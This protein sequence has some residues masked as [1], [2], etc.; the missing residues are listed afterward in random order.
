[1]SQNST[2]Q[3]SYRPLLENAL[4][5]LRKTRTK[6]ETIKEAQ[7]EPIAIIGMG[8]R[9]PGGVDTPDKFWSL[10]HNGVDAITDIPPSR[11]DI[12]AY[13]DSDPDA[14]GKMYVKAG[15]FLDDVEQF[16]PLFFGMAPREAISL[17]PQQR[18]L[19]EVCW[20]ALENAGL[21]ADKLKGSKTGVFVGLFW[22]DY[23]ASHLYADDTSQIDGYRMLSNLRSLSAG[24][25]AYILGLHGP[26]MQVDTACS[27]S[28]LATHL[29]CQS[30]RNQ[31]CHLAIAGGTSL[32]LTPQETI[33]LCRIRALAADGRCKTFDA[34]ADGF[35]QGEGCGL[36]VLKRLS[37]AL[38]DGDNIL[39]LIRGSAVNHDGRSNGLTVPNGTAQEALLR[40]ALTNAA[41]E[42]EQIQY[43]EAHGTGTSLGDPIEVLALAKVLGQ[44]R[45]A[46]LAMGT[47]KTNLGHLKS[48]AGVASLMKVVLS[49]QHAEIPPHLHLTEPNPHIPWDELPL[50]VPTEPT[51]WTDETKRAGVSSFGMS[52]TNVHV[53]VEEAPKN[54]A[55]PTVE[56]KIQ[57]LVLSAT[58]EERLQVYAKKIIDFL[59]SKP[60]KKNISLANLTYT[61]QVGRKAMAER[62]AMVVSS[63]EEVKNQLTQYLQGQTSIEDFYRGN[64]E[65]N[66]AQSEL[67]IEGREGEE[68][69]KIII[70]DKKLNKLAQLWVS[71]LN[72]DWQLLYPN[73]KPQRI[74]LPTYPFARKPYWIPIAKF[75]RKAVGEIG[76]MA[77]LHPLLDSNTSTLS[78]QK[79]TTKLTGEEFY[80]TDH[81]IGSQKT[82]PGVAILEMARA[83]GEI[84]GERKVQILTNMVWARP[85]TVSD[86]PQSVHISL[87]PDNSR[88]QQVEFEVSTLLN[89]QQRQVH[90]QG[91]LSYESQAV[92]DSEKV[93]IEAIQNR[94]PETLTGT[95]CYKLFQ[96]TGLNYGPRFK[97]IQALYCNDT[98]ALSRLQLPTG[99]TDGFN[100]FVLHPSLMD[101]TLQTVIG[102]TGHT[103]SDTPYLPFA[104]GKV[105]LFRPLSDN[106]Y[107]YVRWAGSPAAADAPVKKF[108]ISI[109]NEAGIVSVRIEDFAVRALK[110][111]AETSVT[112]Y[113]QSV[114]KPAILSVPTEP[115]LP[116]GSL[117]LFDTNDILHLRLNELLETAVILV[118]PGDHYQ[119]LGPHTY[120]IHPNHLADYRQLLT[121]LTQQNR[122]PSHIIHLWSQAPFVT[123][124]ADILNAQIEKSLFSIFHLS[125]ALLEQKL[126]DP[127]QLLYIY[128]ETEEAP[129]PQYAALSGFAKTIRLENPKLSYQTVALPT[130]DKLEDIVL[131]EFKATQDIE[132]RYLADQRWVKHPQEWTPAQ[133]T[134]TTLPLLKENGVYLITGGAGGLGLIFAEYLAKHFKAKLVLSGR[135]ELSRE[136]TDKIQ[137]LNLLGAEVLY[138]KA[139]VS[140]REDVEALIAQTKSHFN[141]INGIIHS[142]GVI[143]D[144]LIFRKTP[145]DMTQVLAPKVSGTVYLDD[146]TLSEPLDFFVLFSSIAAVM[147]NVG[148]CDYAYA[149]SFLDNFVTWR[150][151]LRAAKKRVGK[152]LSINWP[153]WQEGGMGVDEAT[154]NWLK[155]VMGMVPL[156]TANG[157]VSFE[158]CLQELTG[159]VLVVEGEAQQVKN[160][161]NLVNQAPKPVASHQQKELSDTDKT[162]LQAQTE[163][164]LKALLAKEIKL[165]LTDIRVHDPLEKYGID[166]VMIMSLTRQLEKDFDEL[167]KT[168]FFEYQTLQKLAGYFIQHHREQVIEKL[169]GLNKAR[170]ETQT[171]EIKDTDATELVSLTTRSRFVKTV[172]SNIDTAL[173]V[174]I[175]IIGVNG[176]YPHAPDL[177]TFWDNL[178][179]GK[180]CVTEIP[181][182][183]WDYRQYYDS[184]KEKAGKAYSKWGGFISEV[185]RFDPL[186]FNIAPREAELMDPQER[187]FLETAWHTL[188]DAGYTKARLWQKP[189]G[190]FVGVMWSEYQLFGAEESLK[191]YPIAPSSSFASIANRI[192][193]YFNFTGPSFALD[194][195]CSSSLT[196]IHL[197]CESLKKGESEI[198]LAGGVNVLIHP[199]KYLSLSQGRFAASDGRCRTFGEGGDGYVPGEGVGAVL[200]KPLNKAIADNDQIY[201]VIKGSSLNHGGKTNGYTVPNPNAQ[202]ELI[203][204]TL[205]NT[206]I[207]PR[208]LSYVEAHGTGTS[209]GDPIE[210]TGLKKAYQAHTS[211][212][213]YCSIGSV[214]SN[215]GHLESA[216]GVA[217]LTKVLLQMKYKQL[218]PSLHSEHLNPNINFADTPFYVQQTH[219]EWN[220]PVIKENGEEKRYPRRAG[221]SSFGAGGANA[222]LILEEYEPPLAKAE[223]ASQ[224]P[225]LIV[226]SAKNEDRLHA[227]IQKII[228]FLSRPA[229]LS[230]ANLAYTLQ[231]GR[232]AMAERLAMVASSVDDVIDKL[233]QYAQGKTEIEAFYRGNVKTSKPQSE[234]LLK[235]KAGEAFLKVVIEEKELSQLAQLWVSGVDIDWQLLYPNNKPQRISVPTYPFA[236]ERYWISTTEPKSIVFGRP[237]QTAKLHP[238]LDSNTS[239]LAE[240]KFT[241]S[242]TG[243]EFY[244]TDHVVAGHKTLPG[245]AILEMARAA[246]ELAGEQPVMR[247]T[248]IV[249]AIPI[250]VSDT[251]KSVHISLYPAQQQRVDFEVNTLEENGSRQVHAQGKLTYESTAVRDSETVD[252]E[253]IQNRCFE[254]WDGGECYKLFQATGL[255]Y[256][257]GFQTIQALHRNDTEALSRLQLPKV[258][259]DGFNDFVLHP[260]LIDGTL[261]T[262]IGLTNQTDSNTSYLPFALGE[263]ELL[264]PLPE[265][266]YAYVRWANSAD[267]AITKF[268]I[269]ILDEKGGVLVRLK[270][271]SVRA[272]TAQAETPVTLYYQNVWEPSV[273][274]EQLG[275]FTPTSTVLLFDTDDS[276]Y[277]SFK[278]SLKSEVILVT[279]GSNYQVLDSQTYSIN[280]NQPAD[281]QKLLAALLGQTGLP[282]HIIH[283]WSQAP[284]GSSEA[285]LNVQI[286]K[287]L[288]SI[289]HLSQA[290]LG[291]KLVDP[292]QLLYI[293]LETEEVLQPQYAALSGF[294]KTIR[295]ENPKLS[296]KTV[297]L[298][299]VDKV[300]DIVLREF[301]ASDGIEIRYDENQR[302]VKRSQEIDK[303]RDAEKTSVLKENGVYLITGGAGGLGLIFADYLARQF[304]AKLVL[305]GR[306]EL[307]A[308]KENEI[309]S[310]NA[311]GAEIIYYRADISKRDE[312][313]ALIAQTKSRFGRINGI[314]HSAG[315]IKDALVLKKTPDEVAAVLAPKIYGTVWLDE[316]T[317]NEPLDF[318]VLFSSVAAILG[319]VGQCDYAS[320]NSFMDNFALRRNSL[321]KQQ[322]RFGKTL[323]INWPLWQSGGMQV[324]KQ[325]ENRLL[326]TMGM[327]ALSTETGLEAFSQGLAWE[328]KSQFVVIE[329]YRQK[330]KKVLGQAA[331]V[332][333]PTATTPTKEVG[334]SQLLEKLQPDL[335]NM[336]S[337]ILK[338]SA[339][340]I[341]LSEDISEYGFDSI[342]FTEFANQINDKY[343]I[344]ITPTIFFE[345]PSLVALSRFLCDEY[346]ERFLDYYK[347]RFKAIESTSPAV[348]R[349]TTATTTPS[350]VKLKS[351][352]VEQ[353]RVPE[354]SVSGLRAATPIAIIGMSG[355]MPQSADLESFW[356]HLEAGDDL[357]TEVPQDRWDWHAYY[358]EG[359]P[360]AEANQTYIKWGGFIPVVDKFDPLFFGIPPREAD[361]MAPEQRLFLETVW[362]TIENAGYKASD[363]SGTQTGLFVG[364]STNDYAE[365]LRENGLAVE[366][367]APTGTVHSIVANRISFLLNLHGPSSPIDT[368]CSSSLVA[369]HRAVEAIH[370]GACSM[371]I[372]GGVN[373]ILSPTMT[374]AFSKTDVLSEDGRCKV[375]DKRA[376]G[377]VRS[378]GVGAILLKPLKKAQADGDTI[379]AVIRSTAENHSG[380]A[381]SLT[382]PNPNAQAQL[383]VSAYENAD[384]DPSTISCIE[385]HSTGTPLGDPIEI[386]ALKKA[387]AEL[388][389]KSGNTLSKEPHCGLCSVKTNIGHLEA[390]SGMAS[391][392]KVLLAMKHKTLPG[393]LHF[394]ELNPYI[395]LQD[396]PFYLVT[397]NQTW[398]PLTD[399][400]GQK[401]PRRAGVS[402][403]GFGG[404]NAHI[405]LEEYEQELLLPVASESTQLMVLSAKNNERLAAVAQQM[406][407]F[408]EKQPDIL[409]SNLT[410]TLQVGREAMDERLAMVVENIEEVKDKLTQYVQGQTE[411]E[412]CYRGNIRHAQSQLFIEGEEGRDF[413]KSIIKNRKLTQLAQLWV[414]G[415]G[416]DWHLIYSAN[417]PQLRISLPTYPF[418]RERYW[419]PVSKPSQS[420]REALQRIQIQ[421][422]AP[423]D[424]KALPADKGLAQAAP[425]ERY[426]LILTKVRELLFTITGFSQIE[427]DDNLIESGIDSISGV[428]LREKLEKNY[429][430]IL[431]TTF[432]RDHPTLHKMTGFLVQ[433]LPSS[434]GTGIE[435]TL[436]AKN[437][438]ADSE[439]RLQPTT[440]TELTLAAEA[441]MDD[442]FK[443]MAEFTFRFAS[444]LKGRRA[445]IDGQ[446]YIDYGSCNYLGLDWDTY[447]M[448]SVRPAL[449]QW[450]VHPPWTRALASPQI[451]QELEMKLAELVGAPYLDVFPTVTLLN[452]GIM[453]ELIGPKDTLF[454][455]QY[456]HDCLQK[457][458]ALCHERGSRIIVFRHNDMADLERRMAA[459]SHPCKKLVA[460]DGV[461]SL[462]GTHA[463]LP[464]LVE[465]GKRYNAWIM[466]DD[467][468]G[469]GV[470]GEQPSP[471][472]PYGKRG[473][474]IAK[475]YGLDYERDGLIYVGQL[476]KAYSTMGGFVAYGDL[477]IQTAARNA[478]SMIFSGPLPTASLATGIA[479]LEVNE[480]EGDK[481]RAIILERTR[482]LIRG[483]QELDYCVPS[484]PDSHNVRVTLGTQPASIDF[485]RKLM[486]E[487]RIIVTPAVYPAVEWTNT[488]VRFMVT[489]LHTEEDIA[490]TLVSMKKLAYIA[491]LK[492]V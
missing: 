373:I 111:S 87:Y 146:A 304:K 460:V 63:L 108:N 274:P 210:I 452:M 465:L 301:Q 192:S 482:Q 39:A 100:N 276:R 107:A 230:L 173:P 9:L 339:K 141:E 109:L 54:Q 468:H 489:A 2:N 334:Q 104:L 76:Q 147:G 164:Y 212:T 67:L 186:F 365:L 352:F 326:K 204:A 254:T 214:K 344:E 116:T 251:P 220:P 122:Q 369:I 327:Q 294:A 300:M 437:E 170:T 265:T 295:L 211:E 455:D 467:A 317:K 391:V 309:Q 310:L 179:A 435:P 422:S 128:L 335:L 40:Q 6:L 356:Q 363:L 178:T 298:P 266:C 124:S 415:V 13:Y 426:A 117:L 439:Q 345:Y 243:K 133:A 237:G 150:E 474:G 118:M 446:W 288:W 401:I 25:L 398:T 202:A 491:D 441:E 392:F 228:D 1:M 358:G 46:P 387:F 406:L 155:Q 390:A 463:P 72:I 114:W 302:W 217:A 16:D 88:P 5:E 86:T 89:N 11:W 35:G 293:Y 417:K 371:A 222:H 338:V 187:L 433:Q 194:S 203:A 400:E 181:I 350:E 411:I 273:L 486:V 388:S 73:Q 135:S 403:F 337:A 26:A 51:A 305:T 487:E 183:R 370:S 385:T 83:A 153:L 84:A 221:I 158:T 14:P 247:L 483:L 22:D 34:K 479:G 130:L 149:N 303:P 94:C 140:K 96:A 414:S 77:K 200:L 278:Q 271:F 162:Q 250:T 138:R 106:C 445:L 431:S 171:H 229:N 71:G 241:T 331:A 121:T 286:E 75:Q 249:W 292:I 197:A 297:A 379:Y 488:G 315:V 37:D 434:A 165:E 404:A 275:P 447:V 324:D 440:D 24:R 196:A 238:L 252:I 201:A 285:A 169:G 102:L 174:D 105:E 332:S 449:A 98:E 481:A 287:G 418:A 208:T 342:S 330:F 410:Y 311:L 382:A 362:K 163:N 453:P 132:I 336:A 79:F 246:G 270:D 262:V 127:I 347:D 366:A 244:L 49:L 112:M 191:G 367:R 7:N 386:N 378:E 27:S 329:G 429:G 268:H 349:E 299:I 205:K 328:E 316:A 43:I 175:A 450:G 3:S 55:V 346:Q 8:C 475:Y 188:E 195:M 397:E 424:L 389:K 103:T 320:A 318:F 59:E 64:I 472:F 436:V 428:E 190:V 396:S 264:K 172:S 340:N 42:P 377:Y 239:T 351:R 167:S 15:G 36:V 41:V 368:A 438:M 152:T 38:K 355:M 91:K 28:L 477:S 425:N 480:R 245:V 199:Q 129:Q 381:T 48:A 85:I 137:S 341:E 443:E 193:Y 226:L 97:T 4:L 151:G 218:V 120:S 280:P 223:I 213:Q 23:A 58:T 492:V 290:L 139:D 10:L 125:Q 136:Q 419:I 134:K 284:F 448:D 101:G 470:L 289:F 227:Y 296:Y 354:G 416:I 209:L 31:E 272:L 361:F 257:P 142:A 224:E 82:L 458:A 466:I 166:S 282:S 115:R 240:Q 119:V 408:L 421:S 322:K 325:T 29:A 442:S 464:E 444:E 314:I 405:V 409:L 376:N 206:K 47:V 263:V 360:T 372:A 236:R 277:K 232:E 394:S 161:L 375:F 219:T 462:D 451:Y 473:N 319:N 12:N 490:E 364:V 45:Q 259:T 454:I 343:R 402:T 267:S 99:L 185:D 461:Y 131:A 430:V 207:E 17:D 279:P 469:F 93:D 248:N 313:E 459:I 148:Q 53:I 484:P 457:A 168:L 50:T 281:Y 184:D 321:R 233:T 198:A 18:L 312:V 56:S 126:K 427:N 307:S 78:E 182:E 62:L 21:A 180:D 44:K 143:R 231:V 69:V 157:L 291:Q 471:D 260:S 412:A 395:Q 399:N 255:N 269:E 423:S 92:I 123:E 177:A 456:A 353:V 407:D 258:L 357:I 189:V 420:H 253:A 52:G 144:A 159:Q 413:V 308:E 283:L 242:L 333:K 20:E 68:F 235:G 261:Q 57:L 66:K 393:L 359:D 32:I 60:A 176:R 90:V 225:Q 256:G 95:E 33:G 156:S 65:T 30:L 348:E 154:A 70:T 432:L 380:H 478:F 215:I 485:L 160:A 74:S 61:L 110:Q 384:L 113:F 216:A 323:S 19:L 234:L 81:V 374:I 80:L 145:L 476:S 306:S 383:L